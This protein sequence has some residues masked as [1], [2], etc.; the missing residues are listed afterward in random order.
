MN[1]WPF[2]KQEQV[3]TRSYTDALTNAFIA[4]ALDG[5]Q[6]GGIAGLEVA[7]GLYSRAF[8]SATVEP[9]NQYTEGVTA[10]V[11]ALMAR[12]LIR[13]G[14]SLH[15][16]NVE[17]GRVV[18]YPVGSWNVYGKHQENDW[19]Y[20]LTF[21]GPSETSTQ[22]VQGASVIHVRYGVHPERPWQGTAPLHFAGVAAKLAGNLEA[23]LS[24][25]AG[26]PVGHLLPVPG[27]TTGKADA[28]LAG[29]QKDIDA[30]RG[31]NV[32]IESTAGSWGE[33]RANSPKGDWESRRL[34]MDAPSS[35][36]TLHDQVYRHVLAACGIPVELGIASGSGQGAREAYRRFI[37]S[38][39]MPL[40]RLVESEL[41][42]KL[43]VEVRLGF[44]D[45]QAADL[46][47]RAVAFK[48]LVEGGVPSGEAF[49]LAS[50]EEL[51]HAE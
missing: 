9:Q 44:K 23:R 30:L 24:E 46:S 47:G 48:K 16:L 10:D 5:T 38:S 17:A 14:E 6:S 50:L 40:A 35:T 39:V 42:N 32:L 4:Q 8:A 33:G 7:A 34:G 13:R 3:E 15:F 45:L 49:I 37:F 20:R 2:K 1:F 43:G 25:E 18:L 41:K 12:N 22:W 36:V 51:S 19:S 11:L 31:Q 21:H 26:G 29:L 27:S 28:R